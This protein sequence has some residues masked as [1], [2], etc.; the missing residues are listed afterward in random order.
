MGSRE[1]ALRVREVPVLKSA[2]SRQTRT[3][4]ENSDSEYSDD[5]VEV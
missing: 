3:G 1:S 5:E 4:E 2:F